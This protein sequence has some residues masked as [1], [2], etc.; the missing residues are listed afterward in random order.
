MSQASWFFGAELRRIRLA[1]RLTQSDLAARLGQS[2]NSQVSKWERSR[3]GPRLSSLA[4]LAEALDCRIDDLLPHGQEREPVSHTTPA[5]R[6]PPE[7]PPPASVT[8]QQQRISRLVEALTSGAALCLVEMYL[9]RLLQRQVS[10][11]P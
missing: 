3:C 1:R 8:L 2:S 11:D 10:G 9:E 5:D 6:A 7:G 4:R